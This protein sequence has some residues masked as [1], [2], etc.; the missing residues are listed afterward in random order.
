[1]A[2]QQQHA[3][4]IVEN[5]IEKRIQRAVVGA[6]DGLHAVQGIAQAQAL[7]VDFFTLR[8]KPGDGSK[9]ACNPG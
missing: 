6:I 2:I 1:M 5:F 3:A 4:G 9:A 8:H 7:A